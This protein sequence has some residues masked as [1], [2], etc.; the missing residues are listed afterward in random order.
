MCPCDVL[1]Q[2][3]LI[4][5]CP[6]WCRP[7]GW[8]CGSPGLSSLVCVAYFGGSGCS[9]MK[10]RSSALGE[11]A[12]LLGDPSAAL[13]LWLRWCLHTHAQSS[14]RDESLS[15]LNTSPSGR[16]FVSTT[17]SLSFVRIASSL[18][19]VCDPVPAF[20]SSESRTELKL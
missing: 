17:W 19:T 12:G 14:R 8:Q 2:T 20:L 4:P 16:A 10:A 3:T 5:R 11:E 6:K 15:Y 13:L 9:A 7:S 1:G 18:C